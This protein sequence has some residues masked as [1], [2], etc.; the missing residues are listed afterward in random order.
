MHPLEIFLY[1]F[2]GASALLYTVLLVGRWVGR[3]KWKKIRKSRMVDTVTV[4]MGQQETK[5]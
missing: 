5:E 1:A 2:I 4:D 3:R